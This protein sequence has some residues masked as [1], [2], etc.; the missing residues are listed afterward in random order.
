M[1]DFSL[2]ARIGELADAGVASLKIEGRLK[3]ADYVYTTSRVY[4]AATE[5][6]V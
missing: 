2:I 5:A 6:W 4:R 1:K 3:G